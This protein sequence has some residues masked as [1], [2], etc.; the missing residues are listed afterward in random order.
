[1]TIKRSSQ[2][3][4][5][6]HRHPPFVALVT[7][8]L[9]LRL[10]GRQAPLKS[11][12]P[13]SFCRRVPNKARK[14]APSPV[15][16][17]ILCQG[18]ACSV[19]LTMASSPENRLSSSH[20]EV[21]GDETDLILE[22]EDETDDDET[23]TD[24][25]LLRERAEI[26]TM[27]ACL[28]KCKGRPDMPII[29]QVRLQVLTAIGQCS[30]L[31]SIRLQSIGRWRHTEVGALFSGL[32]ENQVLI[33]L[34]FRNSPILE[35]AAACQSLAQLVRTSRTLT[36]LDLFSTGLTAAGLAHIASAACARPNSL[37]YLDLA[38]NPGLGT[39]ASDS[40]E[41]AHPVA[42]LLT[43]C[44]A[45]LEYIYLY[46][47]W[48]DAPATRS[49]VRAVEHTRKLEVL[50]MQVG[51]PALVQGL[52]A[53]KLAEERT[54]PLSAAAVAFYRAVS[55]GTAFVVADVRGGRR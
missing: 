50:Q 30:T 24:P 28:R 4:L 20:Q 47:I 40:E 45:S 37:R 39:S 48:F 23:E 13:P 44:A 22:Q 27:V 53:D 5:R 2:E 12:L 41:V 31:T 21:Q 49:I 33:H 54:K 29:R 55:T 3:H 6:G 52:A 36:D 38:C 15:V 43:S 25:N 18:A 34:D 1:M 42:D 19:T 7:S 9:W 46:G 8:F 26:S 10:I 32:L 51:D 14:R 11:L 35:T 16:E 17:T